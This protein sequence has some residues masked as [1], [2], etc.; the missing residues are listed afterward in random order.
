VI[1]RRAAPMR[2]PVAEVPVVALGVVRGGETDQLARDDATRIGERAVRVAE[3]VVARQGRAI[4]AIDREVLRLRLSVRV[5]ADGVADVRPRAEG[6]V[7]LSL[8]RG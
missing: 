6:V 8:G 4:V 1:D 7:R 2:G 3:R 5:Q